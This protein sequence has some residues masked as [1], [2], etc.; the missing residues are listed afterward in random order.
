MINLVTNEINVLNGLTQFTDPGVKLGDKVQEIIGVVNGL[1]PP[2]PEE[3]ID[4]ILIS[5]GTA[6]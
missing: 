6:F 4:T 5:L 1:V 2:P 3:D